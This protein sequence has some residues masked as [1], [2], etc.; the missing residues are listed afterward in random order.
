[1]N[2]TND[3]YLKKG[4]VYEFKRIGDITGHPFFVSDKEGSDKWNSNSSNITIETSNSD[5]KYDSGLI[6]TTNSFTVVIDNNF[7][8]NTDNLY[9]YCTVQGHNMVQEL[10]VK[11]INNTYYFKNW[12]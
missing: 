6:D 3:L 11:E 8:E 2:L 1:M 10:N 7:N 12:I 9:L 4:L 5:I